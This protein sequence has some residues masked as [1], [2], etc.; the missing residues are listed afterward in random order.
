[1]S[2]KI[3]MIREQVDQENG[4]QDVFS[5]VFNVVFFGSTFL[6]CIKIG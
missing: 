3:F 2:H 1:M 5:L 6:V 4:G